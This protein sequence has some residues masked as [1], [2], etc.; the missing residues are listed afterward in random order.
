MKTLWATCPQQGTDPRPLYAPSLSCRR[1][2]GVG[3]GLWCVG[4]YGLAG[5]AEGCGSPR[6]AGPLPPGQALWKA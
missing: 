6:H 5:G 2:Q 3:P 4:S 1:F